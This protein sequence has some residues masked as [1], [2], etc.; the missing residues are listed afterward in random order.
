[1]D[2]GKEIER[3]KKQIE[4]KE[5]HYTQLISKAFKV[6]PKDRKW[7]ERLCSIAKELKNEIQQLRIKMEQYQEV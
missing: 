3:V 6:A 7:S 1:M 5:K 2:S 4:I